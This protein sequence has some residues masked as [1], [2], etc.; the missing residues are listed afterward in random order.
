[1]KTYKYKLYSKAKRGELDN[2]IDRFGIVYNHCI[3]IH[4][5]YFRLSGKHLDRYRLMT[6]LTKLKHRAKWNGIFEGLPAQAVQDVAERIDRSYRLFFRNLKHKVKTSPPSFKKVKKYS[7][8]TLKQNG[9][10]FDGNKIRLNGKWYGFFKSR[11]T[12]G[13][14]KTVTIK[15]DRRGDLWIFVVTDWTDSGKYPKSGKIVGYDFGMKTFLTGSDGIDHDAPLFLRNSKATNDRLSRAISRKQKGSNHRKQAVLAKARYVR[16]LANQ[17]ADFQWKLANRLV[18]Q[19]D[20]LCFEDLNLRGMSA[21]FGRKVGEYGFGEFLVKLQYLARKNG[22]SVRFVDRFFPSSRL[23]HCCGYRNDNL[24]LSDRSWTCP[25]CGTR[26]NR[27][28]NAAT[29]ILREGT[30]SRGLDAVG[31]S[32]TT[33]GVVRTQNP[34]A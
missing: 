8:Y 33:A 29:N 12:E 22:K 27:D 23:C 19:Y 28:R 25:G 31:P 1:M 3:A 11:E 34:M 2:Q 6:H 15:R 14:I 20:V 5:T 7:S 17:R 30:S 10:K 32:E 4:K 18:E 9:Y 13:K 16:H 21:R 26:H 24:R